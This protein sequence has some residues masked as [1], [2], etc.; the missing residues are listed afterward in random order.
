MKDK[1]AKLNKDTI[2][3]IVEDLIREY[4]NDSKFYEMIQH[5]IKI[6]PTEEKFVSW[7]DCSVRMCHIKYLIKRYAEL[8]GADVI[9][10]CKTETIDKNTGETITYEVCEIKENC[11]I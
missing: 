5:E 6:D 11:L 3:F 10:C 1:N 4:D 8:I 9:C 7:H 2:V